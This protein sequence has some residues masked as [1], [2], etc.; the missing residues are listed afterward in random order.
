MLRP[1]SLWKRARQI[2]STSVAS[3]TSASIDSIKNKSSFE[4]WLKSMPFAST[5]MCYLISAP[6]TC[7]QLLWEELMRTLPTFL[8][9]DTDLFVLHSNLEAAISFSPVG[10]ARFTDKNSRHIYVPNRAN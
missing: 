1:K 9:N 6:H 5:D 10:V 2:D 8:P 3:W 4:D 7:K